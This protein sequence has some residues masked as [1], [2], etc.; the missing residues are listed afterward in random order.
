MYMSVIP[1]QVSCDAG[2]LTFSIFYLQ[3]ILKHLASW[4]HH[5]RITSCQVGVLRNPEADSIEQLYFDV[6][7][8]VA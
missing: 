6:T 4:K 1:L 3:A 7:C 8:I 5:D 2:L